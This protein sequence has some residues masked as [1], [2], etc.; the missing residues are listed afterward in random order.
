ME[1]ADG[2]I[3]IF[4]E[5]HNHANKGEEEKKV[6]INII[7]FYSFTLLLTLLLTISLFI[8][9]IYASALI[10]IF[11]FSIT[12]RLSVAGYSPL[13]LFKLLLSMETLV[14]IS[15][16]DQLKQQSRTGAFTSNLSTIHIKKITASHS[17][18][19]GPIGNHHKTDHKTESPCCI[20]NTKGWPPS[21]NLKQPIIPEKQ[22]HPQYTEFMLN[23]ETET[24]DADIETMEESYVAVQGHELKDDGFSAQEYTGDVNNLKDQSKD[25]KFPYQHDRRFFNKTDYKR[26]PILKKINQHDMNESIKRTM[27]LGKAPVEKQQPVNRKGFKKYFYGYSQEEAE[28]KCKDYHNRIMCDYALPVDFFIT[29]MSFDRLNAPDEPPEKACRCFTHL[30]YDPNGIPGEIEI[31]QKEYYHS[32]DSGGEENN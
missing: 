11:Y 24:K 9:S 10:S 26:T 32:F 12:Y 16:T 14:G 3:T 30:K 6:V 7:L 22:I 20:P 27:D 17:T 8:F 2:I 25:A 28:Q 19:K 23:P 29:I 4:K 18:L 31:D 5:L 13:F 1:K 21:Y 15:S